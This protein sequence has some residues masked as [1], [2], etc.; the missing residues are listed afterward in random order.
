MGFLSYPVDVAEGATGFGRLVHVDG[1]LSRGSSENPQPMAR[2]A[3]GFDKSGRWLYLVVAEGRH[4]F[5]RTGYTMGQMAR[6]MHNIGCNQAMLFD[7]GGSSVMV[8]DFGD[9]LEQVSSP[10]DFLTRPIPVMIGVRK[11]EGGVLNSVKR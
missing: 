10:A 7:T 9:G 6:F 11:R 5:S 4:F 8:S 1:L 3:I 2:T